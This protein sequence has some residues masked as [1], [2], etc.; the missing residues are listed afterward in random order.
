MSDVRDSGS[1]AGARQWPV[2]REAAARE[3][4]ARE[5]RHAVLRDLLAA[6]ADGELPAESSSQVEAHLVGCARCRADVAVQRALRDRLGHEPMIPASAGLRARILAATATTAQAPAGEAHDGREAASPAD[7]VSARLGPIAAVSGVASS[8][9]GA[10]RWWVAGAVGAVLAAAGLAV[11]GTE[12]PLPGAGEGRMA[13][14]AA[15]APIVSADA[16]VAV[17]L[18]AA[19]LADYRRAVAGDLPGRARDLEAVRR[20]V[21]FPV[22]PLERGSLRLLAAWTTVL[23]EEPAAVLAYRYGDQIVLEYLVAEEAWFRSPALRRA[24]A[25]GRPLVV[26]DGAQAVVA[27]ASPRGGALLVGDGPAERLAAALGR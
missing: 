7:G 15:P 27:W 16:A 21:G 11:R 3:A 6:Y 23:G 18:V 9:G 25:A 4:A 12:R 2:E 5:A 14:V 17:P 10:R 8:A 1:G 26:R 19:T 13:S 24:A 20:A 22:E